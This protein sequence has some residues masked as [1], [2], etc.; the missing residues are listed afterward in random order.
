MYNPHQHQH[1]HQHHPP[2]QQPR[3]P[4]SA[5]SSSSL[6]AGSIP[7][8]P[9][10]GSGQLIRY[11]S[12]PGSLLSNTVDSLITCDLSALGGSHPLSHYHHH[13]R[14]FSAAGETTS[15]SSATA[16]E[17]TTSSCI[18]KP[19]SAANNCNSYCLNEIAGNFAASSSATTNNLFTK[20]GGAGAGSLVRHSSSPAGLL[21]HLL[22]PNTTTAD[23]TT[24][25]AAE[26]VRTVFSVARGIG[27]YNS[28]G[29][30]DSGHGLSRLSS[31]LSFTRQ[32]SLSHISEESENVAEDMSA[33]NGH[34]KA[35]HFYAT[36]GTGM[37]SW[38]DTN[39]IVF[40]APSSKRA[41]NIT[42]DV[43]HSLDTVES[44]FG[45][46]QT[47]LEMASM[48]KLLQIPQDSVPCKIRAKR[49]CATHP[50]SIAE[51]ERRTRIS[52]KLKKLQDLVPNMD[53]QTSYA[54]MLDLAVQH[55]KGLQNQVQKLHKELENCTCGCK[56]TKED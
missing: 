20:T 7:I 13:H 1:Q 10:R 12:A 3:P 43:V 45:L 56:Q 36:A 54:D 41:K 51:R 30:S 55:I 11:G 25:P 32:E 4:S 28:K 42:D 35:A 33:E 16:S 27:S 37:S 29:V 44:Q 38:S 31:Q 18:I 6:G 17:S 22:P 46:P 47:A 14:Y 40:S 49:G 48:D 2:P 5:S 34:R 53:K 24:S 21:N 23:T 19:L 39:S 8:G 15:S 9:P 50:R 26:N 52:G